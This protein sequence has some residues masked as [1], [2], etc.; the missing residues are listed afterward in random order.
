MENKPMHYDGSIQNSDVTNTNHT[1]EPF[2]LTD[3][4][5]KNISA[6]PYQSTENE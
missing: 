4:M 3:E 5:R 6:N 2:T 1:E